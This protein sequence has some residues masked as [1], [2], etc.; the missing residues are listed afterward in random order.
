MKHV[1]V[2]SAE[3]SLDSP[4]TLQEATTTI[5]TISNFAS[6]PTATRKAMQRSTNI[7]NERRRRPQKV[8]ILAAPVHPSLH[9]PFSDRSTIICD[10]SFMIVR[11][12]APNFSHRIREGEGKGGIN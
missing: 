9:H 11:T 10:G 1:Y 3:N 8:D 4:N 7:N 12:G 2:L 5:D 6:I